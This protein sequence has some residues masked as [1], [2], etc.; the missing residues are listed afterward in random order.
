MVA[1]VEIGKKRTKR[2][3]KAFA[4]AI[5]GKPSG[6]IQPRV[7]SVGPE[8]FGI[9]SVDCAKDRSKWMF[10]DFYGKVLVPP[11]PV[12]HRRS[13]LQSM[14]LTIQ[15][16]VKSQGIQD[17]IACVEMT[18]TYHQIVWRALRSAGFETRLVH[19]FAS[20]H[21]RISEHGDIKTDDHDLIAIFRAALNGFGLIEQPWSE[22]DQS[23]KLLTRH[24]RDLVKKRAKLQSQIRVRLDSCLPGYA[25][26]FPEGDLWEHNIGLMVLQFI[27]DHGGTHHVLL[28]TGI[29]VISK[30]LKEQ[31]CLFQ[32][33]SVERIVAWASNAAT[34]DPL[35]PLLTRLWLELLVDWRQKAQL[36]H[37]EEGDIAGLLAQ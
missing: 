18:G 31:G 10:C 1:K 24:R 29:P 13:D 4:Q 8:R 16:A 17:L 9:V 5:L 30:W 28:N 21:Y 36:I 6:V 32:P 2:R 7:Q 25:G 15:Q 20:N 19:P 33:K 3:S 14:V 34:G 35:H 27:A 12:E 23:I 37:A 26:L 11:T 22:R